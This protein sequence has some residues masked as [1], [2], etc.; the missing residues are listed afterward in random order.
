MTVGLWICSSFP[1]QGRRCPQPFPLAYLSSR[2]PEA[3]VFHSHDAFVRKVVNLCE[4]LE[5][6]HIEV[7]FARLHP[8]PLCLDIP[9]L[10]SH[11][12]QKR[13]FAM[14]SV[15]QEPMGRAETG[16][17]P[18]ASRQQWTCV[19]GILRS[20]PVISQGMQKIHRCTDSFYSLLIFAPLREFKNPTAW[21]FKRE[22][23]FFLP[24]FFLFFSKYS[25]RQEDVLPCGHTCN[26]GDRT[27]LAPPCVHP[28]QRRQEDSNSCLW[29]DCSYQPAE[30]QPTK[31]RAL[32]RGP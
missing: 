1:T 18:L 28:S 22:T 23:Q 15:E 17:Y 24:N 30:H 16:P 20:L 21:V 3:D 2:N 5:L 7:S 9:V 27:V 6:H 32:K 26:A 4:I 31:P 29:T 19:L 25:E 11:G 12:W 13:C 14:H 10:F 8:V